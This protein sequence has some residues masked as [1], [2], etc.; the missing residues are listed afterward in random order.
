[1]TFQD[2][3]DRIAELVE[4]RTGVSRATLLADTPFAELGLDSLGV[5]EI[6]FHLEK[7]FNVEFEGV[8]AQNLPRNVSDLAKLVEARLVPQD[9]GTGAVA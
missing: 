3:R 7:E 9:A 4:Q 6:G 1:M 8:T 5:L 2:L